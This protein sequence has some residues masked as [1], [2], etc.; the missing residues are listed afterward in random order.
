MPIKPQLSTVTEEELIQ[1]SQRNMISQLH[2]VSRQD[3]I[4]SGPGHPGEQAA[5]PQIGQPA[6]PLKEDTFTNVSDEVI[7]A[8]SRIPL[9]Q[10]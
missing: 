2:Q 4:G 3:T 6:G 10:R 5:A 7:Q 8:K 9:R 1:S